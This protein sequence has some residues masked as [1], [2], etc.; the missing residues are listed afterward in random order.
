VKTQVDFILSKIPEAEVVV[1]PYSGEAGAI[2]AALVAQDWWEG[3]GQTS[4]RGFD[5]IERLAYKTMTSV[6]T[7]CHWCPVNCQRSFIDVELDG[8]KGR[9]WS[10]VPLGT[11]WERV[12]VNNSC[13]K[14]LVEDLNEMKVIKAE[15]ERTK[16]AYPNVADMVRKEAFRRV[17]A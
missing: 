4:F 12:I 14:G 1:H 11:G 9:E 3:G 5:A 2:G 15:I 17:T 6:E 10:K 16:D 7:V 8:G 13:P